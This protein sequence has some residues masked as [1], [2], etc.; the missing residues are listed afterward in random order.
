MTKPVEI[1]VPKT[2]ADITSRLT[3]HMPQGTDAR[4][5]SYGELLDALCKKCDRHDAE[6]M[7]IDLTVFQLLRVL[8]VRERIAL[9]V[10]FDDEREVKVLAN[11]RLT[12]W[13][14]SVLDLDGMALA[15]L[16]TARIK[17][18]KEEVMRKRGMLPSAKTPS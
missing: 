12:C 9:S 16:S 13:P 7:V 17:T 14:A 5:G 15:E 6:W 4:T 11:G 10:R 1:Y 18:E 2:F 3:L 8:H